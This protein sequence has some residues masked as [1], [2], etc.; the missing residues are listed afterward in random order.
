MLM[1]ILYLQARVSTFAKPLLSITH[2]VLKRAFFTVWWLKT[3]SPFCPGNRSAVVWFP[4][5]WNARCARFLI[6]VF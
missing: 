2:A 3:S 5:L 6:V 1:K 4:G